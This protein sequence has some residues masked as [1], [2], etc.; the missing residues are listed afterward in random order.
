MDKKKVYK[1]ISIVFALLF[2]AGLVWLIFYYVGINKEKEKMQEVKEEYVEEIPEEVEVEQAEDVTTEALEEEPA[3]S[4]LE[5]YPVPKKSIDFKA[6]ANENPDIYSWITIPDTAIDY[7]VLQDED[8]LDY[9][10]THNLDGS[11]GYP[12]CIY[13]QNYNSKDWDD[14]NTVL[15]GHNMK[16]GSMFAALHKYKDPVFLEE[17]PYVY[18][19]TDEYVLVYEIFAAYEFTDQHLLVAFDVESDEG[20]QSYLDSI[21]THE[22]FGNNFKED[23][24]VNVDTPIISLETCISD[25]PTNRYLVQAVL[26]AKDKVEA[27]GY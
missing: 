27:L 11:S 15:Y 10:L 19:Y 9:Y 16:N 17:H 22:G 25:K 4:P 23:V 1:V 20:Y 13:T 24:V 26:V 18:I 14:H 5:Q 12:G 7:P 3:P 21:F 8:E 6:L 2:V